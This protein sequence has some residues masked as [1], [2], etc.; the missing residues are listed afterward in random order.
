MTTAGRTPAAAKSISA[1]CWK[2]APSKT[3]GSCRASSTARRCG[4]TIQTSTPGT[5]SGAI[6]S[7]SATAAR[8]AAPMA[9][10]SCRRAMTTPVPRCAGASPRSRPR[11]SVGAANARPMAAPIG[12]CRPSTLRDASTARGRRPA[13]TRRIGPS[14]ERGVPDRTSPLCVW[15]RLRIVCQPVGQLNPMHFAACIGVVARRYGFGMIEAAGRDVD[16]IGMVIGLKRQLGAAMGT[17]AAASLAARSEVRRITLHES[18]FGRPY[19]EPGDKRRAGSAPT[20]GAM[21]IRF[22]ERAARHL[23]ANPPAK[24]SALQI[25]IRILSPRIDSKLLDELHSVW[26]EGALWIPGSDI[27]TP[28]RSAAMDQRYSMDLPGRDLHAGR[29]HRDAITGR[30]QSDQCLSSGAF[31]EDARSDAGDLASG[32]KP[33]ARGKSPAQQQQGVIR[34]FLYIE[35]CAAA[36]AVTG[37]QNR[38][39]MDR[40]QQPRVEPFIAF[41]HDR[42]VYVAGLKSVRQANATVLDE[43]NLDARMT[44]PITS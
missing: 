32:I 24:A 8:S 34:E 14:R 30:G 7:N 28:N 4:S 33:L 43:A 17:E 6:R 39:D 18:K 26:C 9:M 44:Q 16:L 20:D 5:S 38:K 36:Q 35:G 25:A 12:S 11:H 31:K 19:A 40:V 3:C 37:R 42:K 21:A 29:N 13:R 41:R 1:G 23:V 2:G 10:I 27:P 22:V 15:S